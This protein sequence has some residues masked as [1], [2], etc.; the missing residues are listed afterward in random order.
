MIGAVLES[1][2][3][4]R[5]Q[6]SARAKQ[7]QGTWKDLLRFA[8]SKDVHMVKIKQDYK[9]AKA[10][11]QKTVALQAFV[12]QPLL[13]SLI[14]PFKAVSKPEPLTAD[15]QS[16]MVAPFLGHHVCWPW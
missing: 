12:N 6:R 8:K 9:K 15:E 3:T 2:A 13:Q 1:F 11:V 10:R 7:L 5:C 4:V 14:V 16:T